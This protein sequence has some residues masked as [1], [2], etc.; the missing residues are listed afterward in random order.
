MYLGCYW[1]RT[2]RLGLDLHW[3]SCLCLLLTFALGCV[4]IDPKDFSKD[5]LICSQWTLVIRQRSLQSV[6]AILIHHHEVDFKRICRRHQQIPFR[7][8]IKGK[9]S[10]ILCSCNLRLYPTVGVHLAVDCGIHLWVLDLDWIRSLCHRWTFSVSSFFHR[11]Q[12]SSKLISYVWCCSE[13]SSY[14]SMWPSEWFDLFGSSEWFANTRP[15]VQL[16]LTRT[17]TTST[18]YQLY[19]IILSMPTSWLHWQVELQL[20]VF[21]CLSPAWYSAKWVE[22]SVFLQTHPSQL[23]FFFFSR[24]K[25]SRLSPFH[26]RFCVCCSS[27]CICCRQ[28]GWSVSEE[29]RISLCETCLH[30]NPKGQI[31]STATLHRKLDITLQEPSP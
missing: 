3:I 30:Q 28:S 7:K 29:W 26:Q 10:W 22:T 2:R 15:R 5:V 11:S 4:S 19:S 27:S 9:D 12:N 23:W 20:L 18:S 31:H 21:G 14:L 6:E 17:W 13:L 16:A 24:A 1:I 8:Q 25:L